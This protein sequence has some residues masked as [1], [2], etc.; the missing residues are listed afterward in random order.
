MSAD[1]KRLATL[2]ARCALAEVALVESTDDRDQ[3]VFVVSRWAM[4]RQMSSLDEV[5]KWLVMEFGTSRDMLDYLMA[6]AGMRTDTA[7]CEQ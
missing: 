2:K 7:H 4:T 5:E 6:E 3:P 1:I